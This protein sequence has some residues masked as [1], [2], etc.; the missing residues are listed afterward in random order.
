MTPPRAYAVVAAWHRS[1]CRRCL[2][3]IELGTPVGFVRGVGPCCP[4]CYMVP[5]R[6][7]PRVSW[8]AA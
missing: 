6:L 2:G 4:A 5:A 3:V 1:W 8:E 7:A